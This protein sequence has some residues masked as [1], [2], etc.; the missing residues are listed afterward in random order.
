MG[1]AVGGYAD[2]A[3]ELRK[4]APSRCE[5]ARLLLHIQETNRVSTL[6]S[7]GDNKSIVDAWC[8]GVEFFSC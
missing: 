2:L 3:L 6:I 8:V 7:G 4:T 1:M 5:E